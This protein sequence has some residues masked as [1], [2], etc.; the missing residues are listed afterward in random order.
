METTRLIKKVKALKSKKDSEAEL[1]DL[2]A[3]RQLLAVS[4]CPLDNAKRT[5]LMI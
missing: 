2:E 4:H 5:K 1:A 3:Q